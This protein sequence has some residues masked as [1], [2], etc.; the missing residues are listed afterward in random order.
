MERS[1]QL[2]LRNVG[3]LPEGP[4]LLF[5]PPR[6][7]LAVRLHNGPVGVRCHSQDFGDYR[8]LEGT[9]TAVDYGVV[10]DLE[11]SEQCV[12][13]HLPREKQLLA[14]LA[15][16]LSTGMSPGSRVWLVGENR[17]GI[18]SAPRHLQPYFERVGFVDMARHCA[19]I[20]AS[21]A[22]RATDF[23]IEEYFENWI[24]RYAGRDLELL[25]LPGL[26]AHGRLDSGTALL[27]DTLEELR[28]QGSVLDFA[29]GSGVIGAAIQSGCPDNDL[30]LLDSSALAIESSRRSLA[31]NGLSG[32]LQASDG[33]SEVRGRYDWIV[34]NP[35]FHRGVRHDLEIAEN[36]FR[37]AGTFLTEKGKI[38][39]VF[40]R[41]LPYLRW[42]QPAFEQVDC[43]ASNSAFAV[44]Q[45]C[46]PTA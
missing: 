28:P 42:L 16:A 13:L 17:A 26:F 31:A 46:S 6:D 8:W 11:G 37:R 19:L 5:N 33:L 3:R 15:H 45:A 21:G 40:N 2:I 7:D 34:S 4:V 20:E 41:H 30:T 10:P 43:L 38:L 14:M 32:R 36:F 35:P 29:C 27:L 23:D 18:K 1:S 9:G 44:I 24:T 39:V 12:I 22:V 25:S